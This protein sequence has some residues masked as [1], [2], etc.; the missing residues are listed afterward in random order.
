MI[1]IR[2]F[3]PLA[4][5]LVLPLTGPV[6][7]ASA[8]QGSPQQVQT[9]NDI[10][11]VGTAM[12][13]WYKDQLAPRRSPETHESAEKAAESKSQ[14]L[15][16][17][18][19]ISNED[20]ARLLVPKYIDAIPAKDGWGKPYEFRLQTQDPNAVRVMALRSAGQDGQYSGDT[21]EVSDFPGEDQTQDIA[22][23][24][25]YFVRWPKPQSS[26]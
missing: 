9:I 1:R 11:S 16:D 10:R 5:L 14:T 13:H 12:F 17:I 3:V 23:I 8:A 21:Y 24:D 26:R 22:W 19:V 2:R 4:L 7:G 15:A 6:Q 18:P 20:L 25:G